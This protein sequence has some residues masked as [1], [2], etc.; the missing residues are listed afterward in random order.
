LRG[1][2]LIYRREESAFTEA[3]E[4]LFKH[5]IL[6]EVTYE[7]VLKRLR[8]R[9]HGLVADWM[10][11]QAGNRIAEYSGLIARHLLLAGRQEQAGEYFLKA[12]QSSLASYANVEAEGYLRQA[13]ELS[14]SDIHKTAW[15]PG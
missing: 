2:E 13:L 7:S 8:S 11:A 12:G 9:Y 6:W 14:P 10:I 3:R 4:Y 15:Q 1:R 5:D